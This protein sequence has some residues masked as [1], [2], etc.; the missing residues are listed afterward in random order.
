MKLHVY[1]T[2][3]LVPGPPEAV[4]AFFDRP[5]NLVRV[6]PP[7]LRFQLLTPT[8]IRMREGALID[9]AVRLGGLSVRWRSLVTAYEPPHRFVDEQLCGPYS[10]WHHTHAFA[11]AEGGT[12][13]T[14]RVVYALPLGPLGELAHA[15]FVRRQV[16]AI[17]AHRR[18]A[19]AA[20]FAAQYAVDSSLPG[21]AAP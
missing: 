19:I 15:L 9:Y 7:R 16:A 6:T 21:E 12:L 1:E 8:P 11:A 18:R 3:Q 13:V 14:D 10:F 2:E 4:F 20:H 5:E 17:F